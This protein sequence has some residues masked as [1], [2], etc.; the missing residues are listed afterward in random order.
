MARFH[1]QRILLQEQAKKSRVQ[2]AHRHRI[3]E[4]I[5]AKE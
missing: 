2:S 3:V 1:L 4:N 5:I